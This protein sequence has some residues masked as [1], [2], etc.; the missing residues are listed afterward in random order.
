MT[1]TSV[2][3]IRILK[4]MTSP[5]KFCRLKQKNLQEMETKVSL[6]RTMY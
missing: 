6:L 5:E 1:M 3:K 2:A 4:V